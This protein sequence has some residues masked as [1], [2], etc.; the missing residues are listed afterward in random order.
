LLVLVHDHQLWTDVLQSSHDHIIQT[1][2]LEGSRQD[3]F[4]VSGDYLSM[5][6]HA[7]LSLYR[8]L[9]FFFV[10]IPWIALKIIGV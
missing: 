4:S 6:F 1:A 10:V 3:V 7:F 9:V 8:L 5:A 2:G